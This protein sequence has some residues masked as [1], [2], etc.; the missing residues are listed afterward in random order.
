MNNKN[1]RIQES[2]SQ[3]VDCVYVALDVLLKVTDGVTLAQFA[4]LRYFEYAHRNGISL[5]NRAV[6]FALRRIV[7]TMLPQVVRRNTP[8]GKI[9]RA[10]GRA[11]QTFLKQNSKHQKMCRN[12]SVVVKILNVHL[13]TIESFLQTTPLDPSVDLR[14]VI[15]DI[16]LAMVPPQ[17]A[18]R[19][20]KNVRTVASD[21]LH[22]IVPLLLTF[23]NI[24]AT[25]ITNSMKEVLQKRMLAK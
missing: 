24:P 9:A 7:P 5:P 13:S 25:C 6:K 23:L 21:P 3:L 15:K 18:F 16:V 11:V 8:S 17:Q 10:V 19:M 1:A 12:I 14:P 4:Q 22:D 20:M 2:L